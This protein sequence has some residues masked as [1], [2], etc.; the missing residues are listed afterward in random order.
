MPASVVI[1]LASV[2]STPVSVLDAW[3]AVVSAQLQ[4]RI[5]AM[6]RRGEPTTMA[7]L[8]KTYPQP[9]EGENAAPL[10]QRAFQLM[11]DAEKK[12]EGRDQDLPIVG[13]GKLPESHEELPP[14]TRTIIQAYLKDHVDAL[15]LL[16]RAAE[17]EGCRFDLNFEDGV[18]MLLPHLGKTRAAARLLALQAI[19]RTAAGQTEEAADS[20]IAGLRL[21]G[22]LKNDPILISGLVR[23]ACDAIITRQLQRWASRC[24]PK[25]ETLKRVEAALAEEADPDMVKHW[26]LGE[27]CFGM[28]AYRTYVL[29]P[30]RAQGIAQMAGV[31]PAGG[32]AFLRVIPEAYFKMDMLA[33]IDLMN[34]YLDALREPYPQSLIRAA[35]VGQDMEHRIPRYYVI[36]RMLF[37]ALGRVFSEGQKHMA[38]M[39]SARVALAVLR[40]RAKHERLPE[41]LDALVP[42]VLDALPPDPFIAEPLRYKRDADGFVIY[43]VGENGQD[44]GGKTQRVDGKAS[45]IGF[46]V[47]WP[48]AEF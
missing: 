38:R 23:I 27:R 18:G 37:P 45:D 7:E 12:W 46:R 25:A 30:N 20:L 41:T 14:A 19:E 32:G 10:L 48:K 33:Y 34:G 1:L 26:I 42:A 17:K 43:A 6:R 24:R 5:A 39:E 36:V 40:Y 29:G 2:L 15:K 35:R 9:P 21:G 44:D 11:D 8:A 47:R 22:A 13:Q 28:D 31:L 4:W 3:D 16:H